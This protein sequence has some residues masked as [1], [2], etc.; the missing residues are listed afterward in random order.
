MNSADTLK[1]VH[2]TRV[3]KQCEHYTVNTD[4][5]PMLTCY[6][7]STKWKLSL[8]TLKHA[9][10]LIFTTSNTLFL[11]IFAW[12]RNFCYWSLKT[13][14]CSFRPILSVWMNNRLWH[15]SYTIWT[16]WRLIPLPFTHCVFIIPLNPLIHTHKLSWKNAVFVHSGETTT[17]K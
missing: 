14:F 15:Q 3:F 9:I 1:K 10:L 11:P 16:F 7:T 13:H 5:G 6:V 8:D 12:K 4:N 17:Q 2:I